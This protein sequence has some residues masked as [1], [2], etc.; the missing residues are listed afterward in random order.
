[1]VD[2]VLKS[3]REFGRKIIRHWYS[4]TVGVVGGILGIV[5]A[6]FAATAEPRTV[7]LSIPLWLW[8]PLLAAGLLV[9]MF[10]AF[11]D[12]RKERDSAR[13]ERDS[14]RSEMSRWS[15]KLRGA[16]RVTG[17]SGEPRTGTNGTVDVELTLGLRNDSEWP[18]RSKFELV[19]IDIAG[20]PADKGPL[21]SQETVIAP[22][23]STTYGYLTVRG[24]PSGWHE[25]EGCF[26]LTVQYGNT[27]APL[28][29]RAS[30][31]YKLRFSSRSGKL[32]VDANPKR[33]VEVEDL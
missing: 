25:G 27:R 16:L 5:N 20:K 8:L 24:L 6:V 19:Y 10:W 14:A 1:M 18:V 33:P 21:G 22:N 31:E 28:Q 3:I 26:K 23:K 32:N 29:Y 9:A 2:E 13:E 15:D 30:W 17:V 12:V 4:V 11:H 7:P